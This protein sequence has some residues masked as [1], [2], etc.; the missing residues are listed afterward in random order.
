MVELSA[1]LA[2]DGETVC[3][4]DGLFLSPV[5]PGLP[6]VEAPP[7]ASLQGPDDGELIEFALDGESGDESASFPAAMEMSWLDDPDTR[8]SARVWMRPRRELLPGRPLSPLARAAATADFANG[9]AAPLPFSDYVF[10]NADLALHFMRE[11]RG[12]WIGLA[13]GTHVV[14]D[15]TALSSSVVHD[16]EGPVAWSFQALVVGLR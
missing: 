2:C 4:A 15:G 9:V 13:A 12:D 16:T 1:T 6:A 11:P 5:P 3:R 14:A 10:I 8:G 7:P